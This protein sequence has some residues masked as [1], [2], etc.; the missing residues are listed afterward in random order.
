MTLDPATPLLLN[1][2]PCNIVF[3]PLPA[4]GCCHAF[5]PLLQPNIKCM[6]CPCSNCCRCALGVPLAVYAIA[7][8]AT[9]CDCCLLLVLP[10]AYHP[11]TSY[12]AHSPSMVVPLSTL[13]PSKQ[14]RHQQQ[15]VR[16]RASGRT[17]GSLR[18]VRWDLL[19]SLQHLGSPSSG[20]HGVM[21]G[22]STVAG[23]AHCASSAVAA[24]SGSNTLMILLKARKR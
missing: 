15:Q 8:A 16:L 1:C 14:Q 24:G 4:S 12:T 6:H 2:S 22:G 21:R 19:L 20:D 11:V 5:P 18:M 17:G 3:L 9:D 23:C 13:V 7:T 10:F